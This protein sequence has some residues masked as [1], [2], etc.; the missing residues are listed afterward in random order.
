MLPEISFADFKRLVYSTRIKDICLAEVCAPGNTNYCY[1]CFKT[2]KSKLYILLN[3]YYS[4]IS[5]TNQIDMNNKHFINV[6]EINSYF[7]DYSILSAETLAL[8]IDRTKS[9]L[10][11]AGHKQIKYWKPDNIGDII[12]L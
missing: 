7:S 2:T 9:E 8:S 5:L 4:F 10:S 3:K 11:S 1:A 6:P 12:F